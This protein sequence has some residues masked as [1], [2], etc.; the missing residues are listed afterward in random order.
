M[1]MRKL[2]PVGATLGPSHRIEAFLGE[3]AFGCVIKCFNSETN[4]SEAVKVATG[5]ETV[6]Q[7]TAEMNILRS[8]SHLDADSCHIVKFNGHFLHKKDICLKFELLDQ[9]LHEYLRDRHFQG[10]P[11]L[12]VRTVLHQLAT[13]LLHLQSAEVIHADLKPQNIM[14]VNRQDDPIQVKIIDFGFAQPTSETNSDTYVQSL[15]YTAP[16]VLLDAPFNEAIDMWTLGLIA[17]E[18]A[19]G[20]PLYPA[21]DPYNMLKYIISTQGQIPDDV[22]DRGSLTEE[23]FQPQDNSKQRWALRKPE[24]VFFSEDSSVHNRYY[25]LRSLDDLEALM[26]HLSG[27]H[28]DQPHFV[29][30]VK[31]MLHLDA[32][33]RI[34]PM[35]ALNHPFFTAIHPETN[36]GVV[37]VN[38]E[39]L[40]ASEQPSCS[41]VAAS[42]I[43]PISEQTSAIPLV[44]LFNNDKEDISTEVSNQPDQPFIAPADSLSSEPD[45]SHDTT[46]ISISNQQTREQLSCRNEATPE[47]APSS[48]LESVISLTLGLHSNTREEAVLE[49]SNK[50][51]SIEIAEHSDAS[52]EDQVENGGCFWHIIR[53]VIDAFHYYFC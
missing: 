14:V 15:P 43:V 19:V 42:E 47:I 53:K 34:K 12:Q 9:S 6:Q 21:P 51:V 11:L 2:F 24:E 39:D 3:G 22:L 52:D 45:T 31:R 27:S 37:G 25:F 8:L 36:Q 30:L 13:A 33:Q 38:M 20:R 40:Q 41:L 4:M 5:Q 50:H 10:L 26:T 46:T 18:L 49:Q 44:V 48:D 16:E 1:S 17:V 32:D 29:D 23:Y 35:E 7:A 28:P